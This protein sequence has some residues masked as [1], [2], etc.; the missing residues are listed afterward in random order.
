MLINISLTTCPTIS[1]FVFFYPE[2][3]I[4]SGLGS[5]PTNAHI[6]RT[7]AWQIVGTEAKNG[8]VGELTSRK[9]KRQRKRFRQRRSF[10]GRWRC[11]WRMRSAPQLSVPD[12]RAKFYPRSVKS[13]PMVPAEALKIEVGGN[14]YRHRVIWKRD[15]RFADGL[16]FVNC[17]VVDGLLPGKV[18]QMFYDSGSGV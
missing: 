1:L 17:S 10:V 5:R 12:R 8:G 18:V 3:R 2:H 6:G 4:C 13:R 15:I 9:R 16:V 14:T 7:Q 11:R